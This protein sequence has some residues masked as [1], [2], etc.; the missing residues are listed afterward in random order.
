M[1]FLFEFGVALAVM[2]LS[3]VIFNLVGVTPDLTV[4]IITCL[5]GVVL[6]IIGI[7]FDKE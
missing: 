5:A 7:I 6:A 3:Y 1:S 4:S 2:N